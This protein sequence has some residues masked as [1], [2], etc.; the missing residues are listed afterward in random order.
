MIWAILFVG[1]CVAGTWG[2]TTTGGRFDDVFNI[3]WVIATAVTFVLA[4]ADAA[5][6][7]FYAGC[8]KNHCKRHVVRPF[9]AHLRSMHNCEMRGRTWDWHFNGQFDGGLQFSPPTWNATGSRFAFAYQAPKL[10][11]K[12]RAVIWASRIGWAWRSTAG[13]PN[14]G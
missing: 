14:C 12:Y 11:Q 9:N 5:D 7:H 8:Q 13:W 4:V 2:Y 1:L 10:E 3:G 6:A